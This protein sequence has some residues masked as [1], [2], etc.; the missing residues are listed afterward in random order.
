MD[1]SLQALIWNSAIDLLQ[2]L[3]RFPDYKVKLK[4]SKTEKKEK[5]NSSTQGIRDIFKQLLEKVQ[6]L[7]SHTPIQ[8]IEKVFKFYT[9]QIDI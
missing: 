4:S 1:F 5:H 6:M 9:V 3:V 8:D 2:F 7:M